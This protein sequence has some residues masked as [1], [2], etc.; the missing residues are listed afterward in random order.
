MP[1]LNQHSFRLL[2]P[3]KF[4]PTSFRRN[5]S[6]IY[7]KTLP[8]GVEVIWAKMKGI[9]KE[10]DPVIPQA[11]RFPKDKYTEEQAKKWIEDNNI[12]YISFEPAK[13]IKESE[14]GKLIEDLRYCSKQYTNLKEDKEVIL[15]ESEILDDTEL[16]L[17]EMLIRGRQK[18][19]PENWK[20]KSIELYQNMFK[21]I[22]KDGITIP[23]NVD[24]CLPIEEAKHKR[25]KCMKE[26]CEK[27]PLY[28]ALWAEGM[29]HAWFCESDF[30]EWA[31]NGDGKGDI[32]YVKEIKDGK[33]SDKFS[34][35]TNPNLWEEAQNKFKEAVNEPKYDKIDWTPE[36]ISKE[37][38]EE[39]EGRL[40]YIY[41]LWTIRGAKKDDKEILSAYEVLTDELEKRNIEYTPID[42]FEKTDINENRFTLRIKYN[43][44]IKESILSPIYELLID[45]GKEYIEKFNLKKDILKESEIPLNFTLIN[46]NTPDGKDY[47]EWMNWQGELPTKKAGGSIYGNLTESIMTVEIKDSGTFNIIESTD[48]FRSIEFNGKLLKGYWLMNLVES[49]W[50]LLKG[51]NKVKESMQNNISITGDIVEFGRGFTSTSVSYNGKIYKIS[52]TGNGGLLLTK[53]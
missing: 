5:D 51:T 27:K 49:G 44:D 45:T 30:K 50:V 48:D 22:K 17:K 23:E 20:N 18:F 32:V 38:E 19:N 25:D 2:N 46:V 39:L 41:E 24:K 11:I 40:K 6:P 53:D 13:D 14:D 21:K 10:N 1:F 47:K 52:S 36:L 4:E 15:S 16:I 3:D 29:G 35:N 28:E 33:A 43:K 34:D 12:K 42:E 9:A 8:A 26:G 7:G 31:M 37:T